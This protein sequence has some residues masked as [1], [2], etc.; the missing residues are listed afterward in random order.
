M[1]FVVYPFNI[2]LA[3]KE[4]WAL[5]SSSVTLKLE[6]KF[7]F[8]VLYSSTASKI[9]LGKS[10]KKDIELTKLSYLKQFALCLSIFYIPCSE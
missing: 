2:V 7:F 5:F 10:S 4:A 6:V 9:M 8:V 3:S 1:T